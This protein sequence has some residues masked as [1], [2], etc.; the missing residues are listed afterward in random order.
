M[1]ISLLSSS[2]I[3]AQTCSPNFTVST[4]IKNSTCLSNGEITVTLG[5][6]TTNIFNVQYGLSSEGGFSINPQSDHVLR[7]IPPGTYQLTVRA[8]CKIDSEYS[9]VKN[10]SNMLLGGNY[11]VKE[12]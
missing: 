4:Q 5:G 7:N 10:L 9:T 12:V 3:G 8:F 1:C 6:D 2:Q 11:K